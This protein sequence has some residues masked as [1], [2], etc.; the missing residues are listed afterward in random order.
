MPNIPW[1]Q[2]GHPATALLALCLGLLAIEQAAR[3]YGR[4]AALVTFAF[5][6]GIFAATLLFV[7][8]NGVPHQ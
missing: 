1:L 3:H 8:I 4:K 7:L 2:P 6:S 5:V